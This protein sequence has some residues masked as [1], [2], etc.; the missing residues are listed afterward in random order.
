MPLRDTLF[1][2]EIQAETDVLR[3][4]QLSAART[5]GFL[6]ESEDILQGLSQ[7]HRPCALDRRQCGSLLV[8][9]NELLK[10][11]VN[12]VARNAAGNMVCTA[13]PSWQSRAVLAA[14]NP[15]TTARLG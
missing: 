9:T 8:E 3:S 5:A 14:R 2:R 1:P 6:R 10:H 7:H 15:K 4:A 12:V 13:V 11:H